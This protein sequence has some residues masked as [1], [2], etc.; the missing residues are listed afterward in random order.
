MSRARVAAL[1]LVNWKGV[2]Y[3]RYLLDRHVTALEG[4]NG[5]GKTTV[6]IAAYVVLLPDMSKL[7]FTNL[8]ESGATGGDRGIWGRLGE[9]GRPSYAALDLELG[10]GARVVAGVRLTR[11]AEPTVEPTAFLIEG[12]GP[13]VRL[14]DVLLVRRDD[15]DHVPELD[16]LRASVVA[17]GG[18]LEVFRAT[19]DYFAALFDRGVTPMRLS[20][21]EERSKLN[22]MLRTSMTGGISRALTSELRGFLLKEE[23]G[24]GDTLGRMRANLDACRRTRAEVAES[25]TLEREISAIYEAGVAM[26][27]AAVHAARAASAEASAEA[28]AARTAIDTAERARRAADEQA[29]DLGRRDAYLEHRVTEARRAVE[30][31]SRAR[32]RQA[33]ADA[34]AARLE[35][36]ERE[37]SVLAQT[38]D[39]ARAA[40]ASATAERAARV[41]RRDAARVAYDRAAAGLANHQDG[42]DELT[43][44]AH[45]HRHLGQQLALARELLE[46]PALEAAD[47]TAAMIETER[48]L[49][50]ADQAHASWAREARDVAAR[51][52]EH[53]TATAALVEI[54]AGLGLATEPV[55]LDDALPLDEAGASRERPTDDPFAR[56]R[57]ALA[58]LSALDARVA[59]TD[60]LERAR[61]D[62]EAAAERQVAARAAAVELG[63]AVG[64]EGAAAGVADRLEAVEA[65]LR[66]LDDELRGGGDAEAKLASARTRAAA[67]AE[68]EARWRIATAALER[69]GAIREAAPALAELAQ[70]RSGNAPAIAIAAALAALRDQFIEQQ[71]AVTASR[72]GALAAREQLAH[73]VAD[74]ESAGGAIAPALLELRDAVGGELLASRFEDVDVDAA[75]WIEARLGPLTQAIIVEDPAA[76]AAAIRERSPALDTVWL[77][78]AGTALDLAPA[79]DPRSDAICSRAPRAARHPAVAAAHTRQPVARAPRRRSA[80]RDRGPRR[81]AR[82]ARGSRSPPRRGPPRRRD[83]AGPRRGHRARRSRGR[84]RAARVGAGHARDGRGHPAAPGHR[85]Q[86]P[87]P[88]PG[89]RARSPAP[90]ARPCRAARA[91]GSRRAGR[92][93]RRRPRR[94]AHRSRSPPRAARRPRRA[95]RSS[96]GPALPAAHRRRAGDRRRAPGRDGG[97]ARSAVPRQ[98]RAGRGDRAPARRRV[99]GCGRHPRCRRRGRARARPAARGR[100]GRD[101]RRRRRGR[102]W[103]R[104]VGGRDH[105]APRRRRRAR[106]RG[107]APRSRARR[108]DRGRW[109]A[110]SARARS[111]RR[112]RGARC[113]RG[114]RPR[115]WSRAARWPTSAPAAP[116]ARSA[117][118]GPWP[119][120]AAGPPGRST[121]S[122]PACARARTPPGSCTPVLAGRAP[123]RSHVQLTADAWSKRELLLDRVAREPRRRRA[124]HRDQG[125]RRSTAA[126]TS[127]RGRRRGTGC[128]AA[129]RRRS[130]R[131][132]IR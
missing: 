12:L 82:R 125:S 21:D 1:A 11:A 31:A 17:A 59:S 106:R 64:V 6:M 53:A 51:R 38:D 68:R 92:G 48:G 24:L 109:R 121:R 65:E 49:E 131:S 120:S 118:P 78:A 62:A 4:A 89:P 2:F 122:G 90:A 54:E 27:A 94:R 91:A 115:R 32:D 113:R 58:R 86:R 42:L 127:T 108:A 63:L 16:E 123:E 19:K 41:A 77:V 98:G 83:R 13:S 81:R 52:A 56:A 73:E 15:G 114:E 40:H 43:R 30:R 85:R 50:A 3:E 110:R 88:D 76:A 102:R 79:D 57:T 128:A 72:A 96:R 36:I 101:P 132:T 7:R 130:P 75:A 33:A 69:L 46:R 55:E 95:R 124:G 111:R 71:I 103:R 45:A 100:E 47:A 93:A 18:T 116:R 66:A 22:E 129:C 60:D 104:A 84:G 97:A 61:R 10:D 87:H 74:L 107:R 5:A 34:I 35:E 44:R 26:F 105:R 9:P 25:R 126:A 67:L 99:G 20:T 112:D 14:A 119:R 39:E 28:A 37:L 8:G 70:V 80:R 23:T 117:R 29:Q